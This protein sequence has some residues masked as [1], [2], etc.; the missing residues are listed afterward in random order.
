[1]S[2]NWQRI[3]A[4]TWKPGQSVRTTGIYEVLDK[5]GDTTGFEIGCNEGDPFPPPP[6]TSGGYMYRLLRRAHHKADKEMTNG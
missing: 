2:P 6:P 5:K 3:A 1:M 4:T